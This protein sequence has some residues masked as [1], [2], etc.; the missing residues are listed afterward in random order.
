MSVCLSVQLSV[1]VRIHLSVYPSILL[2]ICPYSA[3]ARRIP[4]AAG[5]PHLVAAGLVR[6]PSTTSRPCSAKGSRVPSSPAAGRVRSPHP[7]S[8]TS[9]PT[10]RRR[11]LGRAT[12]G[13]VRRAAGGRSSGPTKRTPPPSSSATRLAK[14]AEDDRHD[15]RYGNDGRRDNQ[16]GS[17]AAL[18][19]PRCGSS[20]PRDVGKGKT[21]LGAWR[22]ETGHDPT[23][24]HFA[25]S[26]AA[27]YKPTVV[28]TSPM[29]LELKWTMPTGQ[30]SSTKFY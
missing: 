4:P 29:G 25:T 17:V 19:R 24:N 20:R 9:K 23:A 7:L 3:A 21:G 11:P 10:G 26:G 28:L 13:R 8:K 30:S 18:D 16:W 1:Y 2:S 6:S 14:Q 22:A 12:T 15:G 27:N 5:R